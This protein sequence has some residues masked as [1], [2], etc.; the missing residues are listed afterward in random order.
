MT[1]TPTRARPSPV[2]DWPQAEK[3][4][5]SRKSKIRVERFF[6][7]GLLVGIS[8]NLTDLDALHLAAA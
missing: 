3:S 1:V 7:R 8:S 6:P 4:T 2:V 5:A